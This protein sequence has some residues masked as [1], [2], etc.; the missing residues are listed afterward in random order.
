[1]LTQTPWQSSCVAV[2]AQ[3]LQVP[4]ASEPVS[5]EAPWVPKLGIHAA[6]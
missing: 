4:G 2:K 3:T 6:T 5:E 1:M